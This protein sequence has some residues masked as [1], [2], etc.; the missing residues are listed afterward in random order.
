M[1]ISIVLINQFTIR[2][3]RLLRNFVTIGIGY[4]LVRIKWFSSLVFVINQLMFMPS[5]SLLIFWL[6][7]L[8]IFW[9]NL[10]ILQIRIT[11]CLLYVIGIGINYQLSGILD[12]QVSVHS[13]NMWQGLRKSTMSAQIIPIWIFINIFCSKGD[14]FI[15]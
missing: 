2:N 10:T 11:A 12:N 6:V 7:I 15:L 4:W 13:Y 5:G 8:C 9:Q 1:C 14:N 3:S